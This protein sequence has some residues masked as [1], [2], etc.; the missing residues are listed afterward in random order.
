MSASKFVLRILFVG[1]L[2]LGLWALARYGTAMPT[3]L[4]E[5]ANA[6][7]FS[8]GRAEAILARVL[9]PEIPHPTS[10][11]ES[12][13]VRERI[14]REYARLGIPT[15]TYRA[16]GC[17]LNARYAF[18]ACATVTDI[19][20]QVLP[21]KGPAIVMLSH[22]DSVPAGPG[23]SDDESG[24]AAVIEAARALKTIQGESLHPV[25]AVNTDGEEADLLGAAAFLDNSELKARVGAVVN[26]EARGNQGPSLLF[27]MS[28]GDGR[29]LDLYAKS[30]PTYGTSSLTEVIYKMLPNDTDLTLFIDAGFPSWNLAY[31]G[32]V[33]HYHT[34]LDRRTNLDPAS[35]Q[36][37]GDSLLGVVRGLERTPYGE[38][39]GGDAIYMSIF[40]RWLPRLPATW[41]MPLSL[42]A[43]VV[44]VL[45]FVFRRN[46][47]EERTGG[48]GLALLIL[49]ASIV[50]AGIGGWLL[51]TIAATV[52]GQPDPSYAFP[53]FLRAALALGVLATVVF[54]ARFGSTTKAAFAIWGWMGTL[55][56]VTAIFLTGLSPFF[57]FPL[58]FAAPLLLVTSLLKID[59]GGLRGHAL[60]LAAAVPQLA[61]WISLVSLGET[62]QGLYLHP[63]FTVPAVLALFTLAPL[64]QAKRVPRTT[65][66]VASAT[67]AFG[68]V[69]LAI[70][71]GFEPAFSA[72]SPQRLSIDY[73]EDA[74]AHR[75]YVTADTTAPL[76][77][78]LRRVAAF[79]P[80]PERTNPLAFSAAYVAPAGRPHLSGPL[81]IVKVA[82]STSGARTVT[83]ALHASPETGQLFLA[84]P[85]QA[86][87]TAITLDGKRF[88][89]PKTWAASA[90]DFD[91]I[92]CFSRDCADETV[93]LEMTSRAHLKVRMA[94]VR[95]GLAPEARRI[96]GARPNTAVPSQNGDTTVLLNTIDIPAS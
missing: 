32:N 87:L 56:L 88:V 63:V 85:K 62:I 57:L 72:A 93:V 91:R 50:V 38:L 76:P 69:A 80:R 74:S 6:S 24:T 95:Y 48:W 79:S 77:S 53:D 84:V 82:N 55:A 96:A 8:A 21:G 17:R 58:L 89:L 90:S 81:A 49:P 34:V 25:L 75:T 29:L 52:S 47:D 22:T 20:A 15:S 68:A 78:E 33:A 14:A 11:D 19:I 92:G 3:P 71:A 7:A 46:G 59:L 54:L 30:V 27:Q 64:V 35:L 13:R 26:V 61:I 23:A 18:L 39:R 94:E 60:L 70:V 1:G 51:H 28:P 45:A 67:L 43:L 86:H 42:L 2:G 36:M 65:W 40:G 9:G 44:L 41:A 4:P 12:A 37:Q 83:L 66:A 5:S 16:S 10:S 31:S 73:V